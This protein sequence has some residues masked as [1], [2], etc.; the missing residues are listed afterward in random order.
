MHDRRVRAAD[1][2]RSPHPTFDGQQLCN[3]HAR[4]IV[5]PSLSLARS[6]FISSLNYTLSLLNLKG[7]PATFSNTQQRHR[8]LAM[9]DLRKRNVKFNGHNSIDPRAEPSKVLLWFQVS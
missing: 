8:G 6:S 3:D 5:L 7:L 1:H 9:K 4:I 2:T